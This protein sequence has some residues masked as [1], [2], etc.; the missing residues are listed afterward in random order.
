[1]ST[2]SVNRIARLLL[3]FTIPEKPLRDILRLPIAAARCFVDPIATRPIRDAV[4][5]RASILATP[6][7]CQ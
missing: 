1:M 7:R 5:A 4:R 3:S 6:A 2:L